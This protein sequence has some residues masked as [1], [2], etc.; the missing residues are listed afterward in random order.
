MSR[1]NG[2]NLTVHGVRGW[3]DS[4]CT[5]RPVAG[6]P[7]FTV[8]SPW[9][10][11]KRSPHVLNDTEIVDFVCAGSSHSR[12]W[13]RFVATV[14][15]YHDSCARRSDAP[16]RSVW[17]PQSRPTMLRPRGPGCLSSRACIVGREEGGVGGRA[18]SVKW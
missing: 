6:Q 8:W 16:R 15:P 5:T 9:V 13:K 4:V 2:W 17:R 18:A 11:A 3:P 12:S 10:D 1:R 7:T 14:S